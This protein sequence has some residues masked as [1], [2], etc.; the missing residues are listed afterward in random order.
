ME[1]KVMHLP[2]DQITLVQPDG[3]KRQFEVLSLIKI[4]YY[5]ISCRRWEAFAY[6]TTSDIFREMESDKYLMSCA[7]D[8]AD[9]KE[10]DFVQF[11]EQYTTTQ[12]PL[13]SYES[14]QT[15]LKEFSKMTDLFILI[16]GVL[17]FVIGMIGILNFINTILTGI[18]SRQKEFAMMEAIG[19][20][21]RQLTRMLI[22]EG[23]YFAG[24]SIAASRTVGCLFSLT[25][26]RVL[27]DGIWFM[28]Y[29]FVLGPMLAVYPFLLVLSMLIPYLVYLP[30]RKMDVVYCLTDN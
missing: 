27:A 3:T 19:M 23:L 25:V 10:A 24:I 30:Q 17:S 8:V 22:L 9:D 15:Y 14:K 4:N 21:K 26:V 29:H 1:E 28:Q 16:G 13:M 18:V 7:I 12:E 2:G 5:G 11:V 20:T 6:Y